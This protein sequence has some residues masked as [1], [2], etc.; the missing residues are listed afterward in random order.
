M[1]DLRRPHA[2]EEGATLLFQRSPSPADQ[3]CIG[4]PFRQVIPEARAPMTSHPRGILPTP[5]LT[6]PGAAPIP[7]ALPRPALLPL[8][9]R[10]D[11]TLVLPD[12]LKPSGPEAATVAR[13]V[14]AVSTAASGGGP[15]PAPR[16][17]YDEMASPDITILHVAPPPVAPSPARRPPPR[18][19]PDARAYFVLNLCLGLLIVAGLAVLVTREVSSARDGDDHAAR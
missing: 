11:N 16:G 8:A 9:G 4:C 10:G 6:G 14:Q 19:G 15:R 1:T 18:G 7:T 13:P 5:P 3:Q 12:A 17:S 2:H